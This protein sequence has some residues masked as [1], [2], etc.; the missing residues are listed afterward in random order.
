MLFN[1]TY[2]HKSP[3]TKLNQNLIFF[4]RK[5]KNVNDSA[6]FKPYSNYFHPDFVVQL[7]HSPVLEEKFEAFF[8]VYKTLSTHEKEKLNETFYDAQDIRSII[9]DNSVDGNKFKLSNLPK[10]IRKPVKDLF[11][12]MYPSTLNTDNRLTNH[13][14]D[15]YSDI[16]KRNLKVCPFC[17]I[18]PLF[19]PH[20]RRQDYD[21]ILKQ[22]SYPFSTLNMKNLVPMGRDCNEIFK[23]RKDVI[24]DQVSG[25][26]IVFAYPYKRFY[27]IEI[28][29]DNSKLPD[30]T[31]NK[32][33]QWVINFLP[34]D[35]FVQTW[36]WVFDI[37]RRYSDMILSLY[38]DDW[39]T[40]FEKS[41]KKENK[42][43][44]NHSDLI[45]EFNS[46]A[47]TYLSQPLLEFGI[48]KGA[49]FKFLANC[50]DYSF[51]NAFTKKI[52]S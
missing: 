22:E 1:Y 43:I 47:S 37:K 18:E 9:E 11:S 38:F 33:G 2:L 5:I 3:V 29:L 49:L 26:R 12:F 10:K 50:N 51:Y 45:K 34:N 32:N 42:K 27:Q 48:I 28:K 41:L 40:Q 25:K 13:Y 4:F 44:R 31:N 24:Y 6:N 52:N 19:P 23:G 20:I 30:R 39:L 16:L 14:Q 17:G 7:S 35:S 46:C 15:I 8:N 21:H 36:Q